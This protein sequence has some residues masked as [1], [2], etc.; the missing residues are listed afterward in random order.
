MGSLGSVG[1]GHGQQAKS[2]S[3]PKIQIRDRPHGLYFRFYR[4]YCLSLLSS[5]GVQKQPQTRYKQ[6]NF[7]ETEI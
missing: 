2:K 6:I 4:P 3:Q 5:G 1:C 7:M